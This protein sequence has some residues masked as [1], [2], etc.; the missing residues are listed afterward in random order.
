MPDNFQRIPDDFAKE[1][2]TELFNYATLAVP[3]GQVWQVRVKKANKM[4]WLCEGWRE[5]AEYHSIHCGFFLVFNYVGNSKFNV[6]IFDLSG[7]EIHYPRKTLSI[8]GELNYR[9][10]RPV[11]T[12]ANVASETEFLDESRYQPHMLKLFE[13]APEFALRIDQHIGC[14]DLASLKSLRYKPHYVTR[15]KRQRMAAQ[16]EIVELENVNVSCKRE[17]KDIEKHNSHRSVLDKPQEDKVIVVNINNEDKE[18]Q[19]PAKDL[20]LVDVSTVRCKGIYVL[21]S[22]ETSR[23]RIQAD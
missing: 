2:W 8:G 10:L 11:S 9:K 14:C 17:H 7:C 15:N 20:A 5:F 3:S 4:L 18:H 1:Y 12:C 21:S 16:R 22:M 13:L 19:H 23:K 6:L